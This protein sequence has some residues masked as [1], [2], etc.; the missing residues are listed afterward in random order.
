[1]KRHAWVKLELHKYICV[2]CGCMKR[3]VP[4]GVRWRPVFTLEDGFVVDQQPARTPPCEPGP[5]SDERIRHAG[6]ERV[7]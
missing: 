1:V 5:R 7:A 4:W 2:R 3:N 6:Q